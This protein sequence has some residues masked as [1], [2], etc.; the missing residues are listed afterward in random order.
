MLARNWGFSRVVMPVDT[1]AL[2][3]PA[4]TMAG[5]S[6]VTPNKDSSYTIWFGPEAPDGQENHRVQTL[7]GK[8]FAVILRL[9]GPLEPWFD[10]SWQPGDLERID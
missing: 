8:G 5:R 7:P 2:H 1:L 10:R 4:L 9:D 6:G 3:R